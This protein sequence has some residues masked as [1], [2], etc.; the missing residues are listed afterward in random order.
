MRAIGFALIVLAA[1]IVGF[2]QM[3]DAWYK[4][5]SIYR[6]AFVPKEVP[7]NTGARPVAAPEEAE[8]LA[9]KNLRKQLISINDEYDIQ[10]L[11]PHAKWI[12]IGIS[13]INLGEPEVASIGS[14]ELVERITVTAEKRA[15]DPFLE[16]LAE[17]VGGGLPP[18]IEGD[19]NNIVIF[20]R[21]TQK[22]KQVFD[23]RV[24]IR[25]FQLSY[26]TEP[27]VLVIFGTDE[28]RNDD[29]E[30]N[31]K[32]RSDLYIYYIADERLAKADLGTMWPLEMAPIAG[33]IV[34]RARPD[35]DGDGDYDE[36]T[37]PV[38][39]YSVDLKTL[40]A[41]P[42]IS[43]SMMND[44]QKLLEAGKPPAQDPAPTPDTGTK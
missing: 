24:G 21:E 40:K 29:G 25:V 43:P 44:M 10:Q 16:A 6:W 3:E 32:D 39:L 2:A 19:F 42:F 36:K 1:V 28:D 13:Q 26:K 12:A 20:D 41:S 31:R 37:E 38:Q 27:E 22:L 4:A 7:E 30:I 33:T 11:D 8:A 9:E 34:I 18:T 15:S 17:F 14:Q 35:R 23:R 5:Q